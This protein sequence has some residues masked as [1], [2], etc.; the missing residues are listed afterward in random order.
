MFVSELE[1]PVII[2]NKVMNETSEHTYSHPKDIAV[3]W[4]IS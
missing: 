4:L 1:L 2:R 3:C